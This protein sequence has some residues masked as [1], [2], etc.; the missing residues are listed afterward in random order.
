MQPVENNLNKGNYVMALLLDISGAFNEISYEA[1]VRGLVARKFDPHYIK[2]FNYFIHNKY[3]LIDHKGQQIA[4]RPT[5]GTGQGSCISPIAFN[6]S[7]EGALTLFK[8]PKIY[9]VTLPDL[10]AS[11]T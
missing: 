1:L 4:R 10:Q 9:V 11:T 6:L 7:T 8:P 3:I 5:A 2:W